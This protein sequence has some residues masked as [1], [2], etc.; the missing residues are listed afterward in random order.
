[1]I[2]RSNGRQIETSRQDKRY[3]AETTQRIGTVIMGRR[4]LEAIGK[5]LT[6][7]CNIVY[8]R[9]SKLLAFERNESIWYTNEQP[10]KL[11][12]QLKREGVRG[13]AVIGGSELFELFEK[14]RL[15]NEWHLTISP[16][17]VQDGKPL[18]MDSSKKMVMLKRDELDS[19]ETLF[20]LKN[21]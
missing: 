18:A 15:I 4:T 1:M 5:P 12:E 16:Q 19:G 13:A 20:I 14:A 3:F 8:T 6:G 9:Q 10:R 11:L 17:Y 7:R 2:A 21:A